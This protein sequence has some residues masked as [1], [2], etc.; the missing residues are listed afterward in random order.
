MQYKTHPSHF[1][2]GARRCC[3]RLDYGINFSCCEQQV[4]EA[5]AM[6]FAMRWFLA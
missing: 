5:N 4:V 2:R 1:A 6:H 3:Y